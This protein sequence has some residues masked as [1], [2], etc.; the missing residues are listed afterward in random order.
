MTTLTDRYVYAALRS[1]PEAKRAD[2]DL[3]LRA[4]IEDAVD[5]R[6]EDGAAPAEAEFAVLSEFGDPGR[7]AAGYADRP[8]HLIGPELYLDW[9]RLLKVLLAVVLPTAT[10][11]VVLGQ[12]I[13][14]RPVGEVAGTAVTTLVTLTVHLCFWVTL[15]F[16]VLERTSG[17]K[18]LTEWTPKALP[19][20][21]A[22]NRVGFGEVVASA[23]FAIVFG[24]LL[25]WQQVSSVFHDDAGA[26][27]PLLSPDLWSFWLPYFLA[28]LVLEVVFS[29]V[30]WRR[31]RWTYALAGVNVLTSLLFTVPALW[32]LL[33]G[34]LFNPAFFAEFG[35][36][37]LLE[38][39]SSIVPIGV[40]AVVAITAWDIAD[41]FLK[42]RRAAR[43]P[44]VT[45]GTA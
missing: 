18:G 5:A 33:T 26:P 6:I 28:L 32:L 11:G 10:A 24:G 27:I 23:V 34:Q 30:V 36:Q 31:G 16:A 21:P 29:Y 44:G 38:P 45:A 37:Q 42:A 39:G 13:A 14:Q 19:Q 4:A 22:P 12:L 40:F 17:R 15:V 41:A 3:E 7:L 35:G 20:L 1:L 9:W 43:P 25:V 8:L 2:I